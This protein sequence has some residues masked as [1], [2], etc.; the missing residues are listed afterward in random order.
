M[1]K[2]VKIMLLKI[3]LKITTFAFQLSNVGVV[4]FSDSAVHTQY[5]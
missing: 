1:S 4:Y 2:M 5:L 3:L